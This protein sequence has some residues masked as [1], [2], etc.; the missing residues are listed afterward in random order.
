LPHIRRLVV[1]ED[2]WKKWKELAQLEQKIIQLERFSAM[3]FFSVE[4][5]TLPAVMSIVVTYLII[6][7]QEK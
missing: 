4:R 5:S 1:E 2:D 7:L 3:R 6:L